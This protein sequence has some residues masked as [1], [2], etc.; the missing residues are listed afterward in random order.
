MPDGHTCKVTHAL[1]LR[2]CYPIR[3]LQRSSCHGI[4]VNVNIHHEVPI[5]PPDI[6]AFAELLAPVWDRGPERYIYSYKHESSG[7]LVEEFLAE[8]ERKAH[9]RYT[10]YISSFRRL[11]TLGP[12]QMPNEKW[13]KLDPDRPPPG[14]LKEFAGKRLSLDGMCE[15]KNIAHKSRIFHSIEPGGL[16][17]LLTFYTSKK[18]NDLTADAINPALRAREEYLRRKNQLIERR[19]KTK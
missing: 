2:N 3:Q 7:N 8:L 4:N 14:V 16:C 15:F 1:T 13:R 6:S 5:P 18:E 11:G 12:L 19:A 9:A 17:V 10:N